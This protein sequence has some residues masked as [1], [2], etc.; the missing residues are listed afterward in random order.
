MRRVLGARL[1]HEWRV[2][3]IVEDRVE[4]VVDERQPMLDPDGAAAFA[5]GGVKIVVWSGGAKLGRIALTKSLDRFLVSR[6]S[7][8]GTR[9]S[10]RNCA[11]DRCVSGSKARINSSVSPKKSSRIGAAAPGG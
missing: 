11:V 4:P 1:E 8:I 9:S 6:A 3:D 5:D 2:A 7:L 10:D